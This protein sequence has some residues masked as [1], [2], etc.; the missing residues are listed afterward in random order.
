MIANIQHDWWMTDVPEFLFRFDVCDSGAGD[1]HGGSGHASQI[2]HHP[3]T[4]LW[5]TVRPSHHH[6]R[7]PPHEAEEAQTGRTVGFNVRFQDIPALLQARGER[8]RG[9][10]R[11]QIRRHQSGDG[12]RP[13]QITV[14]V[15]APHVQRAHPQRIAQVHQIRQLPRAQRR[16]RFHAASARSHNRGVGQGL[17]SQRRRCCSQPHLG[18]SR[19]SLMIF[20]GLNPN[21]NSNP[22]GGVFG[23]I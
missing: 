7:E 6:R 8:R 10:G 11:S 14:E 18:K 4:G 13:A 23:W 5:Y 12:V 17:R 9:A 21:A 16:L 20:I 1:L 22:I 19:I 3:G 15:S 2:F